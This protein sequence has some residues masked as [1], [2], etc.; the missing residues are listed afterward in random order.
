M[1]RARFG[2]IWNTQYVV[3]DGAALV[4]NMLRHGTD[5]SRDGRWW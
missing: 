3:C 1:P 5:C 4:W 2:P